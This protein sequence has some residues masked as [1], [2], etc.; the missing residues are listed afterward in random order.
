MRYTIKEETLTNLGDVIRSKTSSI[1]KLTLDEM[2]ATIDSE[3]GSVGGIN[4]S[5][6]DAKEADVV[7]GKTFYAGNKELKT[8]TRQTGIIE[9]L[10]PTY[11]NSKTIEVGFKPKSLC[12]AGRAGNITGVPLFVDFENN[13]CFTIDGYYVQERGTPSACTYRFTFIR[14]DTGVIVTPIDTATDSDKTFYFVIN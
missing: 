3:W 12:C 7:S 2:I 6:A 5:L 14:T 4:L 9:F 10:T 11:P 1:N 8:G 13:R